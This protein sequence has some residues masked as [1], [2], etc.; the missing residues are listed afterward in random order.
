ME[1]MQDALSNGVSITVL[2][3]GVGMSG[4]IFIMLAKPSSKARKHIETCV[5]DGKCLCCE[6]KA[7]KRGLCY[8]CYYLWNQNRQR[9]GSAAKKA[10]YDSKLIRLG[11]LLPAQAVR[12]YKAKDAFS[13]AADEVA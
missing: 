7:L 4:E 3:K 6:R 2:L 9:L 10:E 8:K 11:K 5:A 12:N 13:S 1:G